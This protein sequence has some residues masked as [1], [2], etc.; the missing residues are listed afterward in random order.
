MKANELLRGDNFT[1][2]TELRAD[3]KKRITLGKIID[4][5]ITGYRVYR[6]E[7]GQLLLDPLVTIPASEA[8]LYQNPERI[9]S[10]LQGI[11]EAGEGKL[12][13]RPSYAQFAD[14]DLDES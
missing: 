7:R 9:A 6:N 4:A 12:V 2:I 13:N 10:V 5:K 3:N 14:D 1:E 11:Q 8:W